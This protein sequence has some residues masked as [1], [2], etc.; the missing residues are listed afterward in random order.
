MRLAKLTE[1]R[2]LF[3]TPESAPALS[4]LRVRIADQE[5]PGGR[6][7]GGRYYVDLDEYDAATRTSLKLA[8]RRRQ[9]SEDPALQ[10][11]L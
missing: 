7:E 3:Y 9:L 5:L 4:T 8:E 2:R 10:G 6:I 1:F 11:L